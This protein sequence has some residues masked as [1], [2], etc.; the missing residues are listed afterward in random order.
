MSGQMPARVLGLVSRYD[1]PMERWE[2]IGAILQRLETGSDEVQAETLSQLGKLYGEL[3]SDLGKA[4][5]AGHAERALALN[6]LAGRV[7]AQIYRRRGMR[8]V[9]V[10]LFFFEEFPQLVRQRIHA[11]AVATLILLFSMLIGSL[12]LRLDSKL[13][14]LVVP[15]TLMQQLEADL[16]AGRFAPGTGGEA[17]SA[18]SSRIMTNNIQVSFLAFATGMLL[19]IGTVYILIVNGLMIGGLAGIFQQAGYGVMFWSLIVPHG[20][21][22]IPCILIAAGAG[23][24]VAYAIIDPGPYAR[25][26]WLAREGLVAVKLVCGCIPL[27]IGAALI[28]TWITPLT[29][30][31]ALKFAF[32]AMVGVILVCFFVFAGTRSLQIMAGIAPETDVPADPSR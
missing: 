11:I 1:K 30:H 17:K 13:V 25:G 16:T 7:Y 14:K 27:F 5:E 10:V 32:A 28:E 19:G 22:E 24:I 2:K 4:R 12:C 3:L 29:V 6:A 21:I 8:I 18:F 26:A 9:D 31:A 23:L 20:V 15:E